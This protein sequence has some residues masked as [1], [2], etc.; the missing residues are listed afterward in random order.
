MHLWCL[1]EA[2]MVPKVSGWCPHPTRGEQGPWSPGVFLLS[3]LPC[4]H[5]PLW[6]EGLVP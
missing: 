2:L 3:S 6:A 5:L 4:S 1:H